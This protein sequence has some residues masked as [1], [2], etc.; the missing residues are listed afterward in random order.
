MQ[1]FPLE[2]NIPAMVG[3]SISQ[4]WLD[5]F[6]VRFLFESG[7]QIYAEFKI[8]QQEPNDNIWPFNC[9]DRSGEPIVFHRL[10]YK[11]IIA[12]DRLDFR[13]TLKFDDGST[14]SIFSQDSPYESG[15]IITAE[16]IIIF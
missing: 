4:V 15:L 2:P 6:A 13:L 9:S 16:S 3:D 5:P 14:L 8:E 7:V 1:P 10:L 11:K 12:V